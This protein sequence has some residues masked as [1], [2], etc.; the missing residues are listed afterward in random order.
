MSIDRA[1]DLDAA[2]QTY[3]H[4]DGL[5]AHIRSACG[6]DPAMGLDGQV[7]VRA[8]VIRTG[9]AVFST[10]VLCGDGFV[11]AEMNRTGETLSVWIDGPRI[12]RVAELRGGGEVVLTIEIDGDV[13]RLVLDGEEIGSAAGDVEGYVSK[14]TILGRLI[15]AVY[16]I[17]GS[18][19]DVELSW[20]GRQLRRPNG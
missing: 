8:F 6:A 11:V 9:E 4:V 17:R 10:Y 3:A 12:S 14:Q 1:R 13:R 20:M 15:P 2:L 16:E 5:V 7:H 19:D 18:I